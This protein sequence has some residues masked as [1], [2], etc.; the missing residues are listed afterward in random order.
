[1]KYPSSNRALAIKDRIRAYS[2]KSFVRYVIF[3]CFNTGLSFAVY[4]A[5]IL[6]GLHYVV[7]NCIAW[8]FSVIMA[9]MLTSRY[10]FQKPGML[11]KFPIFALSNLF[12]LIVSM[13]ILSVLIGILSMNP[14][15]ASVLSIPAVVT[16]NFCALKYIVFR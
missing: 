8:A 15:F 13:A 6:L 3:G 7:A 4:T 9:F 1:L 12:S 2:K 5:G 16:M 14:I 10:V 11:R